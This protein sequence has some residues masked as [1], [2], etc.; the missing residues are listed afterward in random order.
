MKISDCNR[1]YILKYE[2]PNLQHDITVNDLKL[3]DNCTQ[4]K[5]KL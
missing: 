3:R 4:Q 1:N 5:T 2:K